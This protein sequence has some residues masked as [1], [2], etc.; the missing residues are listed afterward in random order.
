MEC[1]SLPALH[2]TATGDSGT[3]DSINH[4]PVEALAQALPEDYVPVFGFDKTV[5]VVDR[6]II[7]ENKIMEYENRK[8]GFLPGKSSDNL[9][10]FN[11]ETQP[12]TNRQEPRSPKKTNPVT[13]FLLKTFSKS[14]PPAQVLYQPAV[15][16]HRSRTTTDEYQ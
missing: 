14:P 1:L 16:H 10:N 9:P 15:R 4:I 12:D 2:E 6:Y 8:R 13:R 7:D 5:L 3:G 11:S